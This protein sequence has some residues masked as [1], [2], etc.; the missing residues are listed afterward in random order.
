MHMYLQ[1]ELLIVTCV[2]RSKA[3]PYLHF[4]YCTTRAVWPISRHSSACASCNGKLALETSHNVRLGVNN[5]WNSGCGLETIQHSAA[6]RA[7]PRA[8]WVSDHTPRSHKSRIDLQTSVHAK[9]LLLIQT[10]PLKECERH[11]YRVY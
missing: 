9:S 11:S 3:P 6:P 2:G 4:L 10:Q 7:A 1:F 8:V 5:Y